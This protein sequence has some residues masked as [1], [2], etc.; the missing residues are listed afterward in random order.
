MRWSRW[1]R[2]TAHARTC[3][4]L[5][6]GR[7]SWR[8]RDFR[9]AILFPVTCMTSLPVQ[10]EFSRQNR[11]FGFSRA[12]SV[13]ILSE[14][15]GTFRESTGL[16]VR[17][18]G[19]RMRTTSLPVWGRYFPP[20]PRFWVFPRFF[21]FGTSRIRSEH[22]G[23]LRNPSVGVPGTPLGPF[24]TSHPLHPPSGLVQME[25]NRPTN[26]NRERLGLVYK[27]NRQSVDW[28]L[29]KSLVPE[30]LFRNSQEANQRDRSDIVVSRPSTGV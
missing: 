18:L 13:R 24:Q 17:H 11:N 9:S 26:Q 19:W 14:P 20:K 27:R 3:T 12:F 15:F 23:F 10:R 21:P 29:Q 16:P 28:H 25:W 22:L 2:S 7:P 1:S 6:S 5:T 8:A 4:G 30:Q